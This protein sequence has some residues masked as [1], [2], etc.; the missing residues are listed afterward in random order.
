M[1]ATL[2]KSL[3]NLSVHSWRRDSSCDSGEFFSLSRIR[4]LMFWHFI[5]YG[6][7]SFVATL[8]RCTRKHATEKR[9]YFTEVYIGDDDI[10]ATMS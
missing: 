3:S 10:S 9:I 6:I 8:R 5:S 4:K 2:S 7:A 1:S